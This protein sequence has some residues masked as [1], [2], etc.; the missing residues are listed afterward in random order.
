MAAE[1]DKNVVPGVPTGTVT[2]LFSDIEGST[3]R[4][5]SHRAEMQRA[6][7]RHDDLMRAAMVE[8]RGHIFKTVGDAFCVAFPDVPSAIEAALGAQRAIAAAGDWT[9]VDGLDVR[10]A[11]HTGLA[12]ERNGDYFGPVVNRVAR[13]LAIGHGG[14]VLVSGVTTDLAQGLLPPQTSLR[15]LGPHRLKD[16]AFPEQVYQLCA[17]GLRADFPALRSLDTFAHNLPQQLTSFV[18]RDDELAEIRQL[19]ESERLVTL[20][21]TGGV[22]KTRLALQVAADLL[23]RFPEGV[24][25]IELAPLRDGASIE[26]VLTSVLGIASTAGLTSRQAIVGA[27]RGKRALMLFDNC[28]HIVADTALL[29]EALLMAC[30]SLRVIASSRE[31]LAVKGEAVY[32][33][34][35]LAVP[36]QGEKLEVEAARR[37]GAVA[38]FEERAQQHQR[39]FTLSEDNVPVVVE[40]CRRLDGIA[41]ALELATPK[42]K[43]LS[44]KALLERLDERFR[45]LTG[46]S[47]TALPRQQTMRA[48][49]DWSYDLLSEAERNLFRRVS[50]FVGGWTLEAA[51]S[52]CSD[53]M[54]ADWDIVELLGSLVDKSLVVVELGLEDQ[55]YRMLESTRQYAH[56]RL[57]QSAEDQRFA[58]KH[59][60]Y[61]ENSMGVFYERY[62]S[63]AAFPALRSVSAEIDNLRAAL[64]WALVDATDPDLGA[65]IGALAP[66]LLVDLGLSVEG[67]R[68]L[69]LAAAAYTGEDDLWLGRLAFGTYQTVDAGSVTVALQYCER[70]VEF[71][72]RS[73]ANELAMALTSYAMAL[74]RKRR[75]EEAVR[76][77]GEA[78][79]VARAANDRV[80]LALALRANAVIG[81]VDPACD[82][83]A[84]RSRFE[85]ALRIARA[86]GDDL[87]VAGVLTWFAE[88]EVKADPSRAV[89]L[90]REAF[91]IY[92]SADALRQ[93]GIQYNLAA[94]LLIHGQV[95]E[96]MVLARESLL[97]A[98]AANL[99]PNTAFSVQ[100][101]ALG[102]AL[103]GRFEDAARLFG[104]V[105][106][107]FAS[108][109]LSSDF[110]EQLVRKL[111]SESLEA[112]LA[113]DVLR[114]LMAEGAEMQD[115]DATAL[116]LAMTSPS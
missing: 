31:A 26:G 90:G 13:L 96:A 50:V 19:L 39:D 115:A 58:R 74:W 103:R 116:A 47:R 102:T 11:L 17:A 53:E 77:V 107:Q 97:A 16:L 88:W 72:R 111:S 86:M 80:R 84:L 43:F 70:A 87:R 45:L 110:T 29:I 30:P 46:G 95:D 100:R 91:A 24:W 64:T 21:G 76:N 68:W 69:S 63:S 6:L 25:L 61:M 54:L 65:R 23:E 41:L 5:E 62:W 93:S 89:A 57:V 48:L 4:W 28:E 14:Q 109:D 15:D 83:T 67:F 18:G 27:L 105:E 38:L 52:V 2:F 49:I 9:E 59:A 81:T 71:F 42:L 33:I 3:T 114:K 40:I 75:N 98:T 56:E 44:P 51:T 112:A 10:M 82:E 85:E 73:G 92:G 94:Y 7:R 35:S 108:Q 20:V 36:P 37:Y 79:A 8:H 106:A 32:R 12:D 55:R 66:S 1:L 113:P 78:V 60:E 104:F 99:R 34:P 22:G 101:L